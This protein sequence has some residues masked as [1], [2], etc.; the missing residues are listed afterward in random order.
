MKEILRI[1]F[2]YMYIIYIFRGY[3]SGYSCF[4]KKKK[5]WVVK[6]ND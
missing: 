6:L 2:Y 5:I 3:E 4:I 1:N